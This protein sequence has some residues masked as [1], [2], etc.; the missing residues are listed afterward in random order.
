MGSRWCAEVE[1][2]RNRAS[3]QLEFEEAA[4]LHKRLEKVQEALRARPDLASDLESLHG[5]VMQRSAGGEAVELFPVWRGFLLPRLTL[6]FEVVEGKPVS[7]DTRLR[8]LLAGLQFRAASAR[9][10]GEHLALL[11]RWYYRGTRKGEF[12]PFDS[13]EKLPFRRIVN[14]INRVTK[15]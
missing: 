12:V 11:A 10:R 1:E 4:R 15:D 13:Y 5:L 3:E 9:V 6:T 2:Q 8:K 7:L 14:A